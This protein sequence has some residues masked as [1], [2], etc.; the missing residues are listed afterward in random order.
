[1]ENQVD[2]IDKNSN[3]LNQKLLLVHK[4]RIKIQDINNNPTNDELESLDITNSNN[5]ELKVLEINKIS[6][7]LL[8]QL[9]EKRQLYNKSNSKISSNLCRSDS[10]NNYN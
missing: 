1:M 4:K 5:D 6:D 8:L 2:K 10:F 9:V 3:L 7:E